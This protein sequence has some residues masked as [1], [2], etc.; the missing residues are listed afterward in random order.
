MEY[1]KKVSKGN[2][3]YL[4]NGGVSSFSGKTHTEETK[5]K[6]AIKNKQMIGDRNSQFGTVWI[7][8][9]IENKKIKKDLDNIPEGW[10]KGRK[11]TVH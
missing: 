3:K 4:N 11:N 2:R 5:A 9:G 7:T 6:I 1:R 10:Y 8:N